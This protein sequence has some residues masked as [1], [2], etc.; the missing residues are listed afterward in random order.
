MRMEMK[1][2]LIRK[3]ITQLGLTRNQL[4]REL[5]DGKT[6][7]RLYDEREERLTEEA[8]IFYSELQ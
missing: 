5:Q 6:L 8:D 1:E 4:Y 3:A 2:G 7:E